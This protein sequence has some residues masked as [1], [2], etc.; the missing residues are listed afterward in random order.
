MGIYT[1]I[2]SIKGVEESRLASPVE[3]VESAGLKDH[4]R[5]ATRSAVIRERL[6]IGG[7]AALLYLVW[8]WTEFPFPSPKP[9]PKFVADGIK[10]CDIIAH[11][12]PKK[13]HF[14]K[15]RLVSDRYVPG[16][17]AVWLKN[18]TLWTGEN[19]GEEILR[20]ADVLL[21]GGVIRRIG[22]S[23][24]IRELLVTSGNVQE[25]ELNGAWVTPGIV[26]LHSHQGDSAI[27]SLNGY[28]DG[29]SLKGSVQPWL[30]SLDGFNT[31]D[32]SFNL[33]IAG[34]I[35][36][37]LVLP[38]SA[39]AIGGQAFVFKA[40]ATYE[41]TPSSMQVE[42]PYRKVAHTNGSIG[43][44]VREPDHWRHIKHA[45]GE[46][47]ARV[48]GQTRM[49]DAWDFRK[50]YAKGRELKEKQDR[51][52]ASPSTQTEPFPLDLEWE[53]LADVIRGNVKVNTHCYE[54]TDL[55]SFVRVSNEFEFAV[56]GFHHAHE[57]YLVPDLLKSAYGPE[58]PAVALFALFAR[59]K[60]EA[61]RGSEFAP[62]ILADAG[63]NVV[64]KS[65]HPEPISS[66]FLI[67]EAAQAHHYGLNFSQALGSVTT[68]PA[69][70]M[71]MDHRLGFLRE[72]YDADVVVWDSFPLTLGATPRQT[73]IDGIPQ[74]VNP[75][76][77]DKPVEAQQVTQ[78]GD[79]DREAREAVQSRGDPDL[80]PHESVDDV[81]FVNVA[82]LYLSGSVAEQAAGS[83]VVVRGGKVVCTGECEQDV[84]KDM[85]VVDLK[86]GSLTRGLISV[87]SP[88]GLAGIDMEEVTSDGDAYDVTSV[89]ADVLDGI[90][91]NAADGISFDYKNQLLAYRHGVTSAVAFPTSSSVIA[92][93]SVHYST[94]ALHPLESGAILNDDGALFIKLDNEDMS[95][96]TKLAVLR[97]LLLGKAE[98]DTEVGEVLQKVASGEKPVV[99]VT[100]KADVM[101]GLVR[102]KRKV[103]PKMKI[104]LLGAL[105][106]W[107]IADDL[108]KED[109]G[110]IV[111]PP[112]GQPLTWS[113]RRHLP[114]P[115]LTS[116]SLP[117]YL[118]SRG[119]RVA[120]GTDWAWKAPQTRLEAAWIY[121]NNPEVFDKFS[122]LSLATGN[123]RTLLGLSDDSA[124]DW[125]AWEGDVFSIQ[126][127]VRAVKAPSRARVDLF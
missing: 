96:S 63:L 57:T 104:S 102:L 10:Q 52:C 79:Y 50:A 74:I 90:L 12:P 83:K 19:D 36:T 112:R 78:S 4:P 56:A 87:G 41:N 126:G 1:R 95:V 59:Y 20:G 34:G 75:H 11:G 94:S 116:Q 120:I 99:V 5:R 35:T 21:D 25:V 93:I 28:D 65:D 33:S 119:V 85:P 72:G 124:D 46:N 62:R 53:A 101:A 76:V 23:S 107:L 16:T 27:P 51:W 115:P 111:T 125:V 82:Q 118:A 26:D 58:P 32:Q 97:R 29:N 68:H 13:V 44:W 84:D 88:L 122:A 38:G 42:P 106:S 8:A 60:E 9:V 109:I 70:A 113:S 71:G 98:Q 55:D 40:R 61:Y 117:A 2:G 14:T 22:H 127:R 123:L 67:F 80:H 114:G 69:H 105:E 121:A 103:A 15:D 7:F 17:G 18:A 3:D 91:V 73:Y 66:R 89:A 64:M 31:H 92:G 77:V 100:D 54:A 81:V 47:P 48:Y 86:G 37:S 30:R 108:A 24:D 43:G 110:V 6:L 45:C 39:N 49:D